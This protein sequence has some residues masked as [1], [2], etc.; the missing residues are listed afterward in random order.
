M[1]GKTNSEELSTAAR[2]AR[3]RWRSRRGLLELE[4]LLADFAAVRLPSLPGPQ[5]AEYERLLGYDDLDMH[6]W[7]LDRVSAPADVANIVAEIR[8]HLD[9]A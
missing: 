2:I 5:L 3:A 6:A 8:R 1:N 7:L 4:L 9:R